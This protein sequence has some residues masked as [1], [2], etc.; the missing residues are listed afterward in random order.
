MLGI[1]SGN[2]QVLGACWEFTFYMA[3]HLGVLE[4]VDTVYFGL[5]IFRTINK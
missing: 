2:F 3:V 5:T 1:F 4:Y